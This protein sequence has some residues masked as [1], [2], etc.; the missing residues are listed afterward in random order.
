MKKFLILLIAFATMIAQAQE[1]VVTIPDLTRNIKQSFQV[2][3]DETG[4]M[5][6]FLAENNKIYASLYNENL[7]LIGSAESKMP[8]DYVSE[9]VGYHIDGNSHKILLSTGSGR[10]YGNITFLFD[11]NKAI[12]QDMEFELEDERFINAVQHNN[13]I[14][15]ITVSKKGNSLVIYKLDKDFNFVPGKIEFAED[16]FL[17]RR[18]KPIR[19]YELFTRD[20]TTGAFIDMQHIN[21]DT[22]NSL[23]STAKFLKA[24]TSADN[25]TYTS[26][27]F[28]QFTYI[29]DLDLSLMLTNIQK[30]DQYQFKGSTL[31]IETNS[32][33]LYDRL[34]QIATNGKEMIL[35]MVQ[36]PDNEV[37]KE[38]VVGKKD[39]ITFKNGPILKPKS[40]DK[41]VNS[42]KE[43]AALLRRM[44][45]N[46]PSISAM[47]S[48]GTY[49]VSFGAAIERDPSTLI[50]L[51]GFVGGIGGAVLMGAGIGS[52]SGSFAGYI[53]TDAMRTYGLFD[54]E[55]NHVEG[56]ATAKKFDQIKDYIQGLDK[57]AAATLFEWQDQYYFGYY[58]KA[59]DEYRLVKFDF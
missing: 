51:G 59:D 19:I 26:D 9:F 54:M 44:S 42:N 3:D 2:L 28:D 52:L 30:I 41:E 55:F 43:T 57:F 5:A 12:P 48:D 25:V 23:E 10:Q 1:V 49:E 39:E 16:A 37:I 14:H 47:L 11:E 18:N 17:D 21:W 27:K 6:L 29:I 24:Y 32:F 8:N 35:R 4:N 7:E 53:T 34:F 33:L 45:A 36:V 50:L 13:Q 46:N 58:A 15:L 38:Y 20:D 22:P 31:G 56:T 40:D